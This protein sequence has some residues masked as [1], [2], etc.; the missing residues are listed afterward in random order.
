MNLVQELRSV[1]KYEYKTIDISTLEG[2]K[3]AERLHMQ[4]W[5]TI[6]VTPFRIK[7]ERKIKR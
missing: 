2:L 1:T 7:F 5:K 4:G 6:Q 3:A